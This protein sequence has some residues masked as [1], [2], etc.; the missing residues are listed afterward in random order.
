MHFHLITNDERSAFEA[1]WRAAEMA[2]DER[3]NR[4]AG[5]YADD[6]R[7]LYALSTS[8]SGAGRIARDLLRALNCKSGSIELF[9][10]RH[11]DVDNLAA[12]LRL[13]DCAA[14]PSIIPDAGL[15]AGPEGEPLLTA[16][17]VAALVG[18]P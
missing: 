15:T 13:I 12:A 1:E 10:L 4:L 2:A 8:S 3:W 9:E 5:R 11:L 17:Q 7:T 18:D 6:V 16:G 14:S